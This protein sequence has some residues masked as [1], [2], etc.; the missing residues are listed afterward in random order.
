MGNQSSG[1]KKRPEIENP[2]GPQRV[3]N[4][5]KAS[6]SGGPS[7]IRLPIPDDEDLERRLV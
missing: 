4:L 5:P 6:Q 2:T 1:P 7:G 3:G